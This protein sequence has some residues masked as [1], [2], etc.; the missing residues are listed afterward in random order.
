VL[1]VVAAAS[2]AVGTPI[3]YRI[4][5]RRDGDAAVTYG[6]PSYAAEVLGWRTRRTVADACVDA[7]RW[8]SA[9]PDGFPRA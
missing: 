8:Q 1:E 7:W 6:D 4:G 5:P 2:A 9:N 3:R